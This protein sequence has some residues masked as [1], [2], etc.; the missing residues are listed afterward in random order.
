MDGITTLKFVRSRYGTNDEGS[1]FKRS[2]RQ[3]KVILAFRQKVLSA[4]TLTDPKILVDLVKNF[5]SSIDTDINNDDIPHFV[6]LGQ[7]IEPNALRRVVLD[8]DREG[9][10][11]E[12]GN[13]EDHGGQFVLVPK[14]NMWTDLA[15][16]IQAEIFKFQENPPKTNKQKKN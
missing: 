7:K 10:V 1:D 11:L 8:S 16:Y 3:Q 14:N 5:G 2:A 9:S 4:Q 6:K 13:P 15:E 12:V